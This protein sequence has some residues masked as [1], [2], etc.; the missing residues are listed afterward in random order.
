MHVEMWST[1]VWRIKAG[2]SAK[3]HAR[4]PGKQYDDTKRCVPQPPIAGFDVDVYRTFMRGGTTVKRETDTAHYQA[5]D[6]IICG[7]KP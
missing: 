5:A 1:K 3:R 4:S 2:L 7:K 6:H